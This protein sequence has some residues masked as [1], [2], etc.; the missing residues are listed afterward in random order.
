[1]KS[2]QRKTDDKEIH[3]SYMNFQRPKENRGNVVLF[4]ALFLD[5]F[6]LLP[7]VGEPFSLPFF[8]L[9]AIPLFVMNVW[10]I[11][12][13]INPYKYEH[14]YYFFMGVLG[15]VTTFVYFVAIQKMLYLNLDTK[16]MFPVIA[17]GVLFIILLGGMNWLNIKALYTGTYARLQRHE[18]SRLQFGM[19]VAGISYIIGQILI[20]SVKGET[21]HFSVMIVLLS[22]LSV[23]T[24]FL[25]IYLHRYYYIRQNLEEVKRV[26]PEFNI[27][28]EARLRENQ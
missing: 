17:G 9:G 12:Y 21:A 22:L 3:K 16:G 20:M 1:M 11:V 14:S 8:L 27:P 5:F 7:L 4:V 10:G 24:A 6:G 2:R 18:T 26:Y 19:P 13:I 15:I 25:S 28:K 23:V